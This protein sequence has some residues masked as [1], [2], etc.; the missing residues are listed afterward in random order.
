MNTAKQVVSATNAA[1]GGVTIKVRK[2][3]PAKTAAL[4]AETV[5][6]R[7]QCR[8]EEVAIALGTGKQHINMACLYGYDGASSD[9][10]RYRLNEDLLAR[11]LLRQLEAG[12]MPYVIC[13]DLNVKP[14]ESG[15]I[16]NL[17]TKDLL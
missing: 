17:I 8:W 2:G 14:E 3:V 13:A 4:D 7:D 5:V 1:R 11:A 6:L 9:P 15:V 16:S 10:E 12:D